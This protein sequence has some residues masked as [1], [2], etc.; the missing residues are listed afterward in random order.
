MAGRLDGCQGWLV[1]WLKWSTGE[2]HLVSKYGKN[3]R[4]SSRYKRSSIELC[5]NA[6]VPLCACGHAN[7]IVRLD[8]Y[9]YI[10]IYIV[11]IDRRITSTNPAMSARE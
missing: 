3:A 11:H 6:R 8:V 7:Y 5:V 1:S 9:T 10:H 4:C 2:F